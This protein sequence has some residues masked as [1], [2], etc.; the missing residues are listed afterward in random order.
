MHKRSTLIP[1]IFVIQTPAA[2]S[3]SPMTE[4]ESLSDKSAAAAM[5]ILKSVRKGGRGKKR[6]PLNMVLGRE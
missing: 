4:D 1:F 5:K 2:A 6:S 3:G